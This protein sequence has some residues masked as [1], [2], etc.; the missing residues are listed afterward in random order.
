MGF[1]GND[2]EGLCWQWPNSNL[3]RC[4]PHPLCVRVCRFGPYFVEPLIAGLNDD[5]TPFIA[6]TDLIGCPMVPSDF[7]VGGTCSEQLYGMCESLFQPDLVCWLP[8]YVCSRG[9][10]VGCAFVCLRAQLTIGRRSSYTQSHP[11][12]TSQAPLALP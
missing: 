12:R 7:V 8:C 10:A 11:V 5:G 4:P 3:E 2:C 9:I 6:S 1:G